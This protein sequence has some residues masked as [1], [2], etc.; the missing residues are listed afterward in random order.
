MPVS[1]STEFEGAVI[2]A[3]FT[4]SRFETSNMT[5]AQTPQENKVTSEA[6]GIQ[7]QWHDQRIGNINAM[8]LKLRLNSK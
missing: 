8:C 6:T 5:V 4:R 1:D 7:I 3:N 2:T